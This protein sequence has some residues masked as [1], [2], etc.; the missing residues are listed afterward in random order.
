MFYSR[1]VQ[2]LFYKDGKKR[3]FTTINDEYEYILPLLRKLQDTK[4][5]KIRYADNKLYSITASVSF[6]DNVDDL[7]SEL[8]FLERILEK[9]KDNQFIAIIPCINPTD[10]RCA[11]SYSSEI[12]GISIIYNEIIIKTELGF[13]E[14]QRRY[15]KFDLQF[16][17]CLENLTI[18]TSVVNNH[19]NINIGSIKG[20]NVSIAQA[21]TTSSIGFSEEA[22]EL[23]RIFLDNPRVWGDN[24][25]EPEKI[26][27]VKCAVEKKD[28][29]VVGKFIKEFG[30]II[31]AGLSMIL[32]L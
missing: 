14:I 13:I 24:K 18:P 6:L 8:E 28:S 7:I 32:Q 23:I 16:F 21:G 29:N 20:S 17:N 11:I 3:Q 27:E 1:L 4:Y 9:H 30:P 2:N 19:N 25:F 26:R 5:I 12:F 22:Y 15:E 31:I 10:V